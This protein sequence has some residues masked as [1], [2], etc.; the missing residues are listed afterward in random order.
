MFYGSYASVCLLPEKLEKCVRGVARVRAR[1]HGEG[2]RKGKREGESFE[3]TTFVLGYTGLPPPPRR[4]RRILHLGSAGA[5]G[6][7]LVH[8]VSFE[9]CT[10]CI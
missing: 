9:L 6:V 3:T 2:E 5:L 7:L 4:R 8:C 10:V 1:E